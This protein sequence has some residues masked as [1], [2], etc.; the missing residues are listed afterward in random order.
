MNWAG[1]HNVHIQWPSIFPVNSVKAMRAC[2][3]ALDDG[4]VEEFAIGD[5]RCLL[6]AQPGHQPG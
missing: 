2:I 4:K 1:Y 5:L 6:G 3:A